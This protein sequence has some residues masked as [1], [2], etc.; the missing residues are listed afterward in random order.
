MN[1]AAHRNP[2]HRNPTQQDSTQ[3]ET[4]HQDAHQPSTP[5]NPHPTPPSTSGSDSTRSDEATTHALVP[6][7]SAAGAPTPRNAPPNAA[8]PNALARVG[9]LQPTQLVD[10]VGVITTGGQFTPLIGAGTS[11][12]ARFTDVFSTARDHQTSI[13]VQ[14]GRRDRNG[15]V[16]PLGAL[17][18]D[19][20]E[21][22]YQGLPQVRLYLSISD[23]GALE[24][25]V[26]DQRTQSQRSL[27]PEGLL[28]TEEGSVDDGVDS[29]IDDAESAVDE[30]EARR[31][32]RR[33]RT[34]LL[35]AAGAGLAAIV[36]G[37]ARVLG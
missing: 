37:L 2:T 9:R 29:M 13:H 1:S 26:T 6:S 25:N 18:L 27:R 12:P 5:T 14:L 34:P 16:H 15:Q 10:S 36:F 28:P 24:A 35:A 21:T 31:Q 19:G 7:V 32:K 23:A 22:T 33:P 4:A 20:I 30:M 11:L 3:Q 8:A 17:R